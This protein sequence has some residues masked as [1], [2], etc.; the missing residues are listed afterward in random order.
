MRKRSETSVE[1]VLHV[2][3][4]EQNL[5]QPIQSITK[6]T[7]G[8]VAMSAAARR[9]FALSPISTDKASPAVGQ[10]E[11]TEKFADASR[12]CQ[13]RRLEIKHP[14]SQSRKQRLDLP[15]PAVEGEQGL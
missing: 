10:R 13:M 3:G 7:S 9:P 11:H 5:L 8:A 15:S 6:E 14:G 4:V 1:F 2:L 12:S